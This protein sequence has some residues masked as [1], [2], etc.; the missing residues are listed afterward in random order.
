MTLLQFGYSVLFLLVAAAPVAHPTPR[1][2]LARTFLGR[3]D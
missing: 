2:Y 1:A 3:K